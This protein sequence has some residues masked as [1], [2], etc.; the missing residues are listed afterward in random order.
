MDVEERMD[1]IGRAAYAGE[2]AAIDVRNRRRGL[3][4]PQPNPPLWDTMLNEVREQHVL[5]GCSAVRAYL[6]LV[7]PEVVAHLLDAGLSREAVSRFLYE[8]L[9]WMEGM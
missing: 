2:L 8:V 9:G 7:E 5:M 6:D 4:G 3:W 1:R